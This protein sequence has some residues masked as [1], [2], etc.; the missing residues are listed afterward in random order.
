MTLHGE[1]VLVKGT[2]N[3]S[4]LARLSITLQLEFNKQIFISQI[5]NLESCSYLT[6]M[7]VQLILKSHVATTGVCFV[8]Q[9]INSA[10]VKAVLN[11]L[12]G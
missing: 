11:Q 9:I 3:A 12:S 5:P 1:L 10:H 8:A 2:R 6:K 4:I 7:E